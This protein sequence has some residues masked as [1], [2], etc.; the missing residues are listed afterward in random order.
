MFLDCITYDINHVG[1][2]FVGH[3]RDSYC[4][5]FY[6]TPVY[7]IEISTLTQYLPEALNLNFTKNVRI[8]LYLGT[9]QFSSSYKCFQPFTTHCIRFDVEC[10]GSQIQNSIRL[11]TTLKKTSQLNVLD[12][13]SKN[14]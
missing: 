9:V 3:F 8:I 14:V 1:K 7:E 11:K 5:N 2:G 10:A 4:F 12:H 6:S 13:A